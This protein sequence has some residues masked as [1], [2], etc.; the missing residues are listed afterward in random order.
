MSPGDGAPSMIARTMKPLSRR[1][2]R[3]FRAC[4]RKRVYS[5]PDALDAARLQKQ[6]AYRCRTCKFWHLTT[7]KE[8]N[9]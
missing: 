2:L 1:E 7:A 4:W 5:E 6:R 8:R 3:N 9:R